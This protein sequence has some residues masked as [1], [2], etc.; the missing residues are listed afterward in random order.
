MVSITISV[1]EELKAEFKHF[2]WV[3]WSELSRVEVL[4][5]EI[6]DRYVKTGKLSNEEWKFCEKI[7]WIPGDWLPLKDEFI[8]ELKEVE[9]GPHSKAMTEEE[10]GKWMDAL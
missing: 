2:A 6:F 1:G 4:K 10:F 8:K 7:D 3:N 9:K 5:K